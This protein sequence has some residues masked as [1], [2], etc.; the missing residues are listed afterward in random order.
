MAEGLT[1]STLLSCSPQNFLLQVPLLPVAALSAQ[2]PQ[3]SDSSAASKLGEPARPQFPESMASPV[4]SSSPTGGPS[5]EGPRNLKQERTAQNF[6]RGCARLRMI[7]VSHGAPPG[8]FPCHIAG[9][10]DANGSL[11]Y[12]CRQ[13]MQW[14]AEAG[15]GCQ[16]TERGMLFARKRRW[17]DFAAMA[18]Q[19]AA[20]V[21]R[22][23][24]LWKTSIQTI[25]ARHGA[26]HMLTAPLHAPPMCE[27][28]HASPMCAPM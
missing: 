24:S 20:T 22:Y 25:E 5:V 2:G 9:A 3:P 26:P 8:R 10:S 18:R 19:Q 17:K 14:R 15:S 7:Q 6:L 27:E 23:V 16:D 11:L 21:G 1:Q 12:N 28:L 4:S 13:G